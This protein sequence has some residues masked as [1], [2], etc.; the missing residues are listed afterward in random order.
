M[1]K[2]R[3]ELAPN[4]RRADAIAISQVACAK[5]DLRRPRR[6][7]CYL[8]ND[9]EMDLSVLIERLWR[10]GHQTYLPVLHGAKLRFLRYC[11]N[12]KLKDNH[13]GIPEPV[14]TGDDLCR[15]SRLHTVLMPLV[16]FDN[17]GNRLGMGGGYYDQTF[18]FKQRPG[19]AAGPRLIGVAFDF[20][21]VDTLPSNDWDV[22][23]D[24][25]LTETAL[26]SFTRR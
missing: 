17:A 13:F 26:R 21:Q 5:L 14:S 11:A 12:T 25:I 7:A 1:R 3:R 18:A 24:G 22:A 19:R 6:I 8:P 16:A 2:R 23:L 20:Q 15:P 9:G 10:Q 4:K